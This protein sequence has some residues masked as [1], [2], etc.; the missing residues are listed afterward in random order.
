MKSMVDTFCV[1]RTFSAGVHLGVV[2]AHEGKTV[3]LV[4]ARRLWTWRGAF[5]LNEVANHGVKEGS[6]ISAAVPLIT[7]T[8]AIELIPASP[9]AQE[10]FNKYTE[11][12]K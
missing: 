11:A 8:E 2:L 4:S 1:V 3:Q 10:T 6:R 9:A 12:E 5:T 7:L